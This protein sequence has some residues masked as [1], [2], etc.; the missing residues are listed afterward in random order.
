MKFLFVAILLL[1]STKA[2]AFGRKPV[3]TDPTILLSD[4]L[5]KD[6]QCSTLTKD[7]VLA[8]L[9]ADAFSADKELPVRNWP[10]AINIGHCW[11]LSHAQ[12][13]YYYLARL[14]GNP[15]DNAAHD[16]L[17]MVKGLGSLRVFNSPKTMDE[18]YSNLTAVPGRTPE[19]DIDF[20]QIA[21][22]SSPLNFDL[23]IGNWA[24]PQDANENTYNLIKSEL[25]KNR[26]PLIILRTSRVEQH[27]L[28][29]KSA[30]APA[31]DG[32]V[33]LTVYD[34]NYPGSDNT[35]TYSP[36]AREFYAPE[37][38]PLFPGVDDPMMPVGIFVVDQGDMNTIQDILYNYY[39]D[40]CT[41]A[42]KK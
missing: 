36:K 8:T 9:Q 19:G 34:S 11:S 15:D 14:N 31:D 1:S 12:R 10:N 16:Y 27:V 6:L 26:M 39:M 7:T 33:N 2:H 17:E 35:L 37:I 40:R 22:F 4:S 41:A 28:L 24:R 13:I 25:S 3:T 23:L 32:S 5:V 21:R 30:S 18:F 42:V 38:I 29:V 20:Y